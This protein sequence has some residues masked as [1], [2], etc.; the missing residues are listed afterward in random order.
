[1]GASRNGRTVLFR[2]GY[3]DQP[4]PT[5]V[6]D[7]V[8]GTST[9]LSLDGN[10]LV[11]EG[12]LSGSGD[13]ALLVTTTGRM[14]RVE[15][16]GG[17]P[18]A[19]EQIIAPTPYLSGAIPRIEIPL[20]APGN[21][22][23]LWGVLDRPADFWNGSILVDGRPAAILAAGGG[24]VEIQ[25]PWDVSTGTESFRLKLPSEGSPFEQNQQVW[26]NSA[27]PV[28]PDAYNGFLGLKFVRGDW[29]DLLTAQPGPGDLVHL[30]MTGL[31]AVSGSPPLGQPASVTQL[32][33]LQGTLTCRFLPVTS[34]ARTLFVGLAPGMIGVYQIDF[35]MPDDLPTTPLNG[36]ACTLN[37]LPYGDWQFATCRGENCLAGVSYP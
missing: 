14:V 28:F 34:P 11:T 6:A 15:V 27:I 30:Y 24:E 25:V 20:F 18:G 35:R 9:P 36:I 5:Y 26:V 2:Y 3:L 4:G 10:E 7:S 37:Q 16:T 22:L 29:S 31:G 12:T 21:V 17:T 23:Q 8:S 32:F 1:M 19:I 33:P 13:Q